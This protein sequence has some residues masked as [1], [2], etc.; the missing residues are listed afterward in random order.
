MP[1]CA[2]CMLCVVGTASEREIKVDK[3]RTPAFEGLGF[4][5]YESKVHGLGFKVPGL[6]IRV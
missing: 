3:G 6:K 5:V 1:V 4:R 2:C